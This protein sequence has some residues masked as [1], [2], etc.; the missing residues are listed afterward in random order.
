MRHSRAAAG[1]QLACAGMLLCLLLFW[2]RTADLLY[3]LFFGLRSY[4]GAGE[5]LADTFTTLR[6]W[7][8]LLTGRLVGG[9]FAGFAFAIAF[10]P[11]RC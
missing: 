2:L 6:G 8:L 5:A 9:L 7:M 1:A 10:M 11:C 3:A 4:P